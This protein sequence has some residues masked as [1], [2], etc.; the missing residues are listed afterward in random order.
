LA[1][2]IHRDIKP[3]NLWLEEPKGR[4]KILDFGLARAAADE[5]HLTQS[6]AI[7]GTPAYMAPEQAA[8][9]SVDAR[10]DLFSLGCVLY[11]LC[12]GVLPFKGKDSISTLMAVA[13]E[14]PKPPAAVNPE[15]PPALSELVMHLLAKKPEQRPPSAQVVAEA[16]QG[17]EQGRNSEGMARPRLRPDQAR[18]AAAPPKPAQP[19]RKRPPLPWLLGAG[20]LGLGALLL[21]LLL[22]QGAGQPSQQA[23]GPPTGEKT[24][25]LPA[26]FTNS[27]GMELVLVPK[28]K[29]W[30]GGGGGRPGDKEVEI[31]HDFYLGKYEVT[32]EE[33]QKLTGSN[34]SQFQAVPG[35]S[36]EDQRR[37]PVE[38]VSWDDAQV[39]IER[40]NKQ[41]KEAG[42][43]YR[44]PTQ[45]EW[46]YACRGGP[47]GDKLDSAF[48]FYLEKP[49][50]QLL[51]E[52]ANFG[53]GKALKRPCKVGSYPPNRLGLYDMH[54][55]V[56]ELCNDE[57][58][59]DGTSVRV[60]RGGSWTD[61][62]CP[63]GD[64]HVTALPAHRS[65][66][67]GLRL[68]RIPVGKEPLSEKNDPLTVGSE[69]TGK[70]T[71]GSSLVGMVRILIRER[72]GTKWKGDFHVKDA[73]Q[74]DDDK[75]KQRG[76]IIEGTITDGH[77]EFRFT[78]ALPGF[79]LNVP[80]VIGNAY[81]KAVLRDGS[82]IEGEYVVPGK[83]PRVGRLEVSLV[84]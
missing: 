81:V 32:Q 74:R 73:R 19:T 30:L 60:V 11:R 80:D 40:L 28:G 24:I 53:H 14:N 77:V 46:E 63:T 64:R 3:A 6:G 75:A 8:G 67:L 59:V 41:L 48:D 58:T 51:P 84:K 5:A 4:V 55:N 22:W 20:A 61:A 42:W 68:A 35:V 52:Q 66:D 65:H 39:F 57:K 76:N 31:V 50:S 69:W 29:S 72:Q 21:V 33:W 18:V 82:R 1:G 62:L 37:F 13:T 15:V 17:I 49:T 45:A 56:W 26:T 47:L 23:D 36:K 16:L 2:L 44:L 83:T 79:G 54:G 38:Q 78:G 71:M 70:L 43:V 9:A 10:C 12:T 25:A 7:V 27:L 34:P